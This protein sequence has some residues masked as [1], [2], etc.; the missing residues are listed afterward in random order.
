[1]P[2]VKQQACRIPPWAAAA[3]RI[4]LTGFLSYT[5]WAFFFIFQ[6]LGFT[7]E[8]HHNVRS[9]LFFLTFCRH[10]LENLSAFHAFSTMFIE[11]Q[12]SHFYIYIKQTLMAHASLEMTFSSSYLNS[13]LVFCATTKQ[14]SV[15]G[16]AE[17]NKCTAGV[18]KCLF[19]SECPA[20]D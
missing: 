20:L 17:L 15:R 6:W 10:N 7:A 8:K 11:M 12:I 3:G 14:F 2:K 18:P 19:G 9:F 5:L 4:R 13:G 1:M 16:A